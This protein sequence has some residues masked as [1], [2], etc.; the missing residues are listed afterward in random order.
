MLGRQVPVTGDGESRTVADEI[1][2]PTFGQALRRLRDERGFSREHLAYSAGVS[3]SYV[4]L[5]EKGERGNP[6]R[7][8]VEALLR[9]L[10]T[11]IPLTATDR[12]HL[13]DLAGLRSEDSPT[14]EEL[15]ASL[16]PD[17]RD[18]LHLFHPTL[19][20]YLDVCGNVLDANDA[21]YAALPGLREERNVFH[22][23]FGNPVAK[24]V[25]AEWQTE[26]RLY[27]L[28]LRMT[29]GRTPDDPALNALVADLAR[30][31]HFRHYWTD[32]TVEFT[33]P[34]RNL[35][36]RNPNSGQTREYNVQAGPIQSET[37]PERIVLLLCLP[38]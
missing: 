26:A 7:S 12:R 24:L 34:V 16:T 25:E 32:N 22:W 19:A 29:L 1:A 33:P 36:L 28:W 10:D 14:P 20:A 35:R 15:L 23:L 3:A 13:F 27:V 18:A 5:L 37:Y 8:V 4:T 30:Y 21:W 11:M 31:P 17:E 38:L 2:V 6:T 9:C